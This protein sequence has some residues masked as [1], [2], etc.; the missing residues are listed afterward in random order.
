MTRQLRILVVIG[1]WPSKTHPYL[2]WLFFRLKQNFPGLS[3]FHYN[4]PELEEGYTVI[5][6]AAV[7]QVLEGSFYRR[8]FGLNPFL[9]LRAIF[10][11]LKN[12]SQSRAVISD[13]RAQGLSMGQAYGQLY[14]YQD[15]LGQ[16]FDLVHI[17]ALQTACHFKSKQLFGQAKVLTSS[18]G[19]DFDFFSGS[20]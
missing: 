1:H 18:R 16:R 14:Y 17:N 15:L 12:L 20:L 11:I 4:Q 9:H 5:G 3:L 19:Q 8:P 10:K 2:S 7:N 6:K 13:C